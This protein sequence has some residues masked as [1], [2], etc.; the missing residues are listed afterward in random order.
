M[1]VVFKSENHK[2]E[3]LDPNE[4]IDWI[5]VTS[6]VA[7]F[8]QKFDPIAQSIKSSKNKRSKWY[9]LPPEEIQ[10]HWAKEG[11][12]AITAGT[13]YHDQREAD[14][15][16]ID[17]INRQG[18]A[19]P[20]IKPIFMDGL[21][22]APVQRL[23]EGIYPEH[24]IFLKSAGICGQSDRVEVV[25]DIID[26][27]DYKTNKEIKKTSFVNWEG[28]SQK[29][30]GPCAHLDD[31]N[32]NHYSLQLSIY[33][34]MILKHNP[35]YKPGKLM[36][37]HVIFEKDGE[38]KWSNPILKKNFLGEPLVKTVVPYEVPY[39]KSEV[40]TMINWLKDNKDSFKK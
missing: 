33:M 40:N 39:L 13:F 1:S 21:K 19:I 14:L 35:R 15:M 27:I 28:K 22:H 20:I 12:R 2:Y 17:T 7:M 32:F 30:L 25:K 4:R 37:H 10:A 36:L 6:F 26:V 8:K 11:D 24:F 16:E 5:S 23:G 34:Y 3:S 29:M 18:V 31:C 38:D 9:G